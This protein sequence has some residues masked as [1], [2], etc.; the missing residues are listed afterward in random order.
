MHGWD[1]LK[2][3][4]VTLEL[5]MHGVETKMKHNSE[6]KIYIKLDHDDTEVTAGE[7]GDG[8]GVSMVMVM[9]GILL[10]TLNLGVKVYE[11]DKHTSKSHHNMD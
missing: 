11:V 1:S 4:H 9:D 7:G 10:T 6:L 8:C 3:V 2:K 5:Y